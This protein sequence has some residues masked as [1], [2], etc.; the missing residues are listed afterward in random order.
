MWRYVN[1]TSGFIVDEA[2]VIDVFANVIADMWRYVNETSGFIV[3][4]ANVID[5]IACVN[6]DISRYMLESAGFNSKRER[7]GVSRLKLEH[8]TGINKVQRLSKC[9]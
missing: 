3:D 4:E 8:T 2:N 7:F 5:V 9:A 6:D 1:E